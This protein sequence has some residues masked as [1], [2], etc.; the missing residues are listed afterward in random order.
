M[1]DADDMVVADGAEDGD[2]FLPPF[3]A[4]TVSD[5]AEYPRSVEE[6]AVGFGVEVA[7][8]L[9]GFGFDAGVFGVDVEKCAFDSKL[10]DGGEGVNALPPE[11]RGVEIRADAGAVGAGGVAEFEE[12]VVVVNDE[13]GVHFDAEVDI[14]LGEVI[15]LLS[16]VGDRDFVPLVFENVAVFVGPSAGDPVRVDCLGMIAGAAAEP[17]EA[18]DAKG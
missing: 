7:V 10:A 2:E 14:V 3:D 15:G 8:E 12:G 5:G 6:I 9:A 4:V 17:I 1:L 11:V 13:T 16:P 18:R